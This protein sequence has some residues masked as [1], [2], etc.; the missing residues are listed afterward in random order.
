MPAAIAVPLI[1]AGI[2]GAT[3]LVG[4]HMAS[5]ASKNAAKTQAD[6]AKQGMQYAQQ[7]TNQAL[8]FY[9]QALAQSQQ[10]L[11]PYVSLGPSALSSLG[12]MNGPTGQPLL[13][14]G[15]LSL[16]QL[17]QSM[18]APP[19]MQPLGGQPQDSGPVLMQA[20]TGDRQMVPPHMVAFYESQGARRIPPGAGA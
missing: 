16:G 13:P 6:A 3:S 17:G 7:T 8:P 2:S 12:Q 15:S 11:S 10:N 20:P 5:N 19:Q 9:N 18:P 1:G 14:Q 4:A